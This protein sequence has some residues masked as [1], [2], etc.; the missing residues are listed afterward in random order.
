M[1]VFGAVPSHPHVQPVIAAAH[2]RARWTCTLCGWALD[3][4]HRPTGRRF[5]GRSVDAVWMRLC[6]SVVRQHDVIGQKQ[7]H[8]NHDSNKLLLQAL[9]T[10]QV[11]RCRWGARTGCTTVLVQQH[12][13]L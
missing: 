5:R 3:A 8:A 4:I 7:L 2:P 6:H 13:I 12:D 9:Q 11:I 1:S 10:S